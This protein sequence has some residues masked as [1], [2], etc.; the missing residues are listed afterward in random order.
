MDGFIPMDIAQGNLGMMMMM[1]MDLR[2]WRWFG[3]RDRSISSRSVTEEEEEE[4]CRNHGRHEVQNWETVG[5]SSNGF[6]E[7]M[8][9][10]C[11]Q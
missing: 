6:Y 7:K 4:A 2:R 8:I 9:S 11:R 3:R 1:M 10:Y 5:S